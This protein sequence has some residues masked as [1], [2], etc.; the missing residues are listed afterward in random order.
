MRVLAWFADLRGLFQRATVLEIRRDP[1]RPDAVV[2]ELGGDAGGVLPARDHL[3]GFGLLQRRARQRPALAAADGAEQRPLG[4]SGE[5]CT[6][7]S[8]STFIPSTAP[9]RAKL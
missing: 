2:A 3:I 6:L 9:M 8:S 1:G 4:T 5:A 7:T